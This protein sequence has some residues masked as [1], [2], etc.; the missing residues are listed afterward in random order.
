MLA[1]NKLENAGHEIVKID[2]SI[3]VDVL[4]AYAGI[5]LNGKTPVLEGEKLISE[6][7]MSYL[8][9]YIPENTWNYVSFILEKFKLWREAFSLRIMRRKHL[10]NFSMTAI[11]W[12]QVEWELV[13]QLD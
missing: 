9:E 7:G 3:F 11:L 10:S 2:T 5:C 8:M 13:A 1:W 4:K 6:Y 12:Q